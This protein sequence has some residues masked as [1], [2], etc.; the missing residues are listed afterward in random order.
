LSVSGQDESKSAAS[1]SNTYHQPHIGETLPIPPESVGSVALFEHEDLNN[2]PESQNSNS[3]SSD[4]NC[5]VSISAKE[6]KLQ[7]LPSIDPAMMSQEDASGDS[8]LVPPRVSRSA[9]PSPALINSQSLPAATSTLP[10]NP[11]LR[12][13]LTS[14][15][16]S[17]L[18]RS[19]V[20]VA[21]T[22]KAQTTLFGAL[23]TSNTSNKR[24]PAQP[25]GRTVSGKI[26]TP[27]RHKQALSSSQQQ[28]K[29]GRA[30]VEVSSA[31][32]SQNS[33]PPEEDSQFTQPLDNI[34]D[35][36]DGGPS[37]DS[38]EAQPDPQELLAQK[39]K[40]E[41]DALE[42]EARKRERH[43][44]KA[45]KER[46]AL[47]REMET[48]S[49]HPRDRRKYKGRQAKSKS[50]I[51]PETTSFSQDMF[52]ASASQPF[53]VESD[54]EEGEEAEAQRQ[55]MLEERVARDEFLNSQSSQVD[56]SSQ[57]GSM[58]LRKSNSRMGPVHEDSS[59]M[60]SSETDARCYILSYQ[61]AGRY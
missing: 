38:E 61:P 52:F 4:L 58:L 25:M 26:I 11:Q 45:E 31:E 46:R 51:S 29:S 56:E 13:I 1:A 36:R 16:N 43:E 12:N 48:L 3:N 37:S 14:S 19:P 2:N 17:N 42:Q 34:Y 23:Q 9:S 55:K 18:G 21:S 54:S 47:E 44:K 57:I 49:E 53:G 10:K 40:E 50:E 20:S 27:S 39:R 22:G 35:D 30:S 59:S 60:F 7:L 33:Q 28:K 24:A 6:L 5:E 15:S 32:P 41:E 8:Q